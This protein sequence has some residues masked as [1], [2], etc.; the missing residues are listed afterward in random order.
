VSVDPNSVEWKPC[1]RKFVPLSGKP[2]TI[3]KVFT[4]IDRTLSETFCVRCTLIPNDF[5][6]HV[7]A[8]QV[9]D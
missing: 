4:K 9:V 1:S 2:V 3:L 5:Y 7:S 8:L 6:T